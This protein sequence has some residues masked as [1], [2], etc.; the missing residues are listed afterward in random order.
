MCPVMFVVKCSNYE[1]RCNSNFRFF[2]F[3][4]IREGIANIFERLTLSKKYRIEIGLILN[5]RPHSSVVQFVETKN[6]YQI[7][8]TITF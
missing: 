8:K 3:R 6:E 5:E 2:F 4:V 7:S 1:I